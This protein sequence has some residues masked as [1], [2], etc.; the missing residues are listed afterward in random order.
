MNRSVSEINRNFKIKVNGRNFQGK[1]ITK[2]VGVKGLREIIGTDLAC[3]LIDR[4]FK[5]RND[6]TEC[7][8]R[9]GLIIRFY[10]H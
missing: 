8:L 10:S 2:L 1:Y 6:V 3:K 9:R 5:E 7:R 4:A